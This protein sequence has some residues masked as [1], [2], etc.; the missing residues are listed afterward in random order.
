MPAKTKYISDTPM[1]T[2]WEFQKRSC[3]Y[4]NKNGTK[5]ENP[6][7]PEATKIAPATEEDRQMITRACVESKEIRKLMCMLDTHRVPGKGL[8]ALLTYGIIELK[9]FT[10]EEKEGNDSYI[11]FTRSGA[12]GI[13]SKTYN[14][15]F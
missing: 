11:R 1:F 4:Y 13:S 14:K 8:I 2:Y 10:T 15:M 6:E 5:K 12:V 9:D 3:L 7:I